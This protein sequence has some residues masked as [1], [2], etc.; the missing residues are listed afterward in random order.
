MKDKC[1]GRILFTVSI[2]STN[3]DR[4]WEYSWN[5]L[6]GGKAYNWGG[7]IS[8]FHPNESPM[9]QTHGD[10]HVTVSIPFISPPCKHT[11][12]NSPEVYIYIHIH[13]IYIFIHSFIM[14]QVSIILYNGTVLKSNSQYSDYDV[15]KCTYIKVYY[16]ERYA[17]PQISDYVWTMPSDV[18]TT[19]SEPLPSPPKDL[20]TVYNDVDGSLSIVWS[21]VFCT[22][23]DIIIVQYRISIDNNE[24]GT[25]L[26]SYFISRLPNN[27]TQIKVN[28]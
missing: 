23:D 10:G 14:Y 6:L 2:N 28:L 18:I 20:K 22:C 13:N 4:G 7:R 27:A 9:V 21:P 8:G 19:F 3:V 25:N 12:S 16:Q 5:N 24:I 11:Y 15:P 17:R 26:T 1:G